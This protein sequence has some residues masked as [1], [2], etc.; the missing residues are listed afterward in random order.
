MPKQI[1]LQKL[2]KDK[3]KTF[4]YQSVYTSSASQM[5]KPQNLSLEDKILLGYFK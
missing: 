1:Y 4:G 2:L 3:K 5:Q